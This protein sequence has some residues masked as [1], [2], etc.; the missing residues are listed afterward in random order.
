MILPG[1]ER[2]T[3]I[4]KIA[5]RRRE[6]GNS[7]PSTFSKAVTRLTGALALWLALSASAIAQG[8]PP[9]G[10][11]GVPIPVPPQPIVVGNDPVFGQICLHPNGGPAPCDVVRHALLVLAVAS[12]IQVPVI[13]M[14]PVWGQTCNGPLGPGPCQDIKIWI[15]IRQVAAQQFP[16]QPVRFDPSAGPICLGP[17]GEGRCADIQAYLMQQQAGVTNPGDPR[18]AQATGAMGVGGPLCST[19]AGPAP[20]G[21]VAQSSLDRMDGVPT[22]FGVPQGLAPQDI[23]RE[24]AKRVGLDVAA[25]AGCAGQKI[26]L[27][28]KQQE[29]LD[30]AVS[31]TNTPA[32]AQCAAAPL[33]VTLSQDQRVLAGC[34]MKS[35]GNADAFA[36]CAG[37][38]FAAKALGPNEKAILNC[39]T[40]G[41]DAAAFTQC[42]AGPLLKAEQKAVL[43][44]A[45]SATDATSFATCAA[46]NVGIKLS[47]DQ[48]IVAR[49]AMK[50]G[51]DTDDFASCAGAAFLGK[52]LSQDQQAVLGCAANSGGDEAK[53]AG[54]AANRLLG[55]KLSKEQQIAVQC[56][57]QSGG[58]VTG[59]ATCAGANLFNLQ[60]NP[61][62]QIAVQCVVSTGGMPY[63]AAGCMASR[64]TARELTKC[65]TDGFGG[66]GCFGDSNDLVG[67]DGWVA[68]N[69]GQIAGGPNS[70][71]RNPDQLLGGNNSFVRNPGQI[72]G[73]DNSFVRNPGQIWGGDNSFVRNPG[74]FWG[75]NNSVFNNPQQLVPK[76]IQLGK[77]GGKRICFPWC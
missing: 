70:V 17:L 1:A 66:K 16:I 55:N 14:N 44:C 76:P 62:Q 22:G 69:L 31:S 51:G 65:M 18:N 3:A 29:V 38:A 50:S 9:G 73:G 8:F 26:V 68:R 13:G 40:G 11:P 74:T 20:C 33:G 56:A 37:P 4:P 12:T 59:M 64:L 45:I 15:A 43:D 19:P 41:G 2:P 32:F 54:C 21:L 53:F 7:M 48:R 46:P 57:A 49:C 25:F 35:K 47:D 36:N 39:A 63:A 34:A 23:A 58:D 30:C 28:R 27:P 77:V 24:C 61:E 75:G 71:F 42:A 52:N 6:E 72:W 67:K 10:G 60:L 5:V